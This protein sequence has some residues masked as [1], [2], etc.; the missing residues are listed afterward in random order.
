MS[1]QKER[2]LLIDGNALIHRSFH[3]LPPTLRTKDGTLVNAVYGFASFLLSALE[4]F[5]PN[6]VI[7]TLDKAAPTF[8]HLAYSDYKAT[9]VKTVDELYEQIPL[10]KQL[11]SALSIPIFEKEGFEADDLIGTLSLQAEKEKTIETIIVTGDLD[12]LQLVSP[13]T[14]VY[15]MSRGLN[16]SVIYDEAQVEKRFSLQPQQIIDYKALAGDASDN[17]PG[18]KGIG[19]KT[20]TDL[21][22]SYHNIESIYQALDREN[23]SIKE[24][25]K[26]LLLESQENVFL[27]KELATIDRQAPVKLSLAQAKFSLQDPSQALALFQELEFKSLLNKLELVLNDNNQTIK[28]NKTELKN[29][30]YI[31]T[32]IKNTKELEVLIGAIEKDK[33]FFI[34]LIN[35]ETKEE[36]SGLLILVQKTVYHLAKRPGYL[37]KLKPILEDESIKKS[38]YD[39]KFIFRTLKTIGITIAGIKFDALLAAYLLNPGERRYQLKSLLYSELGWFKSDD[40]KGKEANEKDSLEEE[41]QNLYQISRLIPKLDKELKEEALDKV[42]FKLELPLISILGK[43]E[44]WG[45]KV[46][47]S[48]LE[49]LGKTVDKK[50]AV[51]E[52]KI[53]QASQ[54]EFNINSPKQLMEI[55]FEHLELPTYGIKKTKTGYSTAEEELNK[56]IDYHEIIPL[57]LSYRELAKINS[58]YLKSL[59]KMI[60]PETKRI[61][62][63]FDQVVTSTGRLSSH[64]P[65]LQNIPIKTNE[66]KKIRQAFI[67]EAGYSL[68]S[69]DYS[70]IELRIAAHYS[71]DKHMLEA[72]I[73]NQDIH[74]EAAAKINNV[75]IDKVTTKMRQ[76]AKAVNFGVLYGQGPHGLSQGAGV[77]YAKA[78]DFINKYFL[79]YPGIKL[80]VEKFIKTAENKGY[81]I[82]LFG[83]KRCLPDINSSLPMQK[84]AAQRMA[85][86]A[87]VQGTAADIIKRAMIDIDTLIKDD[88]DGIRLLLQIHDE[89]IFEVR[90]D[91]LKDYSEK[92]KKIM[93]TSTTLSVPLLIKSSSGKTWGDL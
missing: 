86:N 23:A 80:M 24:R 22:I 72:F 13:L 49:N 10:V 50:L 18:A 30:P 57:I 48:F 55:L 77:P 65:N 38:G 19:A 63:Y 35:D 45:I 91:L 25:T 58:T 41:A 2:L 26:K 33:H 61:H 60:N 53:Y 14:K 67:A 64:D 82:T 16:D 3:A 47:K 7:L 84:R 4:E 54:L 51:L 52:D 89:L 83:R 62:S 44:A 69:F 74:I 1:K 73:K 75:T 42:Y 43:M 87:P 46:N 12:T 15:T 79:N 70:Q 8:R 93:E 81:A 56:L 11:V 21:L 40:D 20:A 34:G 66:G 92:I 37:A 71:Q 28:T 31:F 78:Q 39:L 59:P 76:E 68:L 36:F 29:K 17:I 90:N 9:R 5:K 27:S 88:P 6:Y 85:I 32:T